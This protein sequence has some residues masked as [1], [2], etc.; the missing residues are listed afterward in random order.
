MQPTIIQIQP[1]YGNND[2]K[3][4]LRLNRLIPDI[5]RGDDCGPHESSPLS[6]LI[7]SDGRTID[8]QSHKKH[9]KGD[10][11]IHVV[12]LLFLDPHN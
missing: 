11:Y 3:L 7:C 5:Y 1:L 8:H 2:I 6:L 9:P 12:H 4:I 10:R